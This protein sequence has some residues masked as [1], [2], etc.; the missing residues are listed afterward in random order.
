M[1]Q[2]IGDSEDSSNYTSSQVSGERNEDEISDDGTIN[3]NRSLV[4]MP[5]PHNTDMLSEDNNVSV[6]SKP[7]GT[8]INFGGTHKFNSVAPIDNSQEQESFRNQSMALPMDGNIEG[9]E[10]RVSHQ[11]GLRDATG[12]G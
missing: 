11:T 3:H 6:V 10:R 1:S 8:P 2:D 5:I 9:L 12:L 4:M 7:N